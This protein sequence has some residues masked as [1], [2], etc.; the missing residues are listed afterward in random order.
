[1]TT[2]STAGF[3]PF[4]RR[5]LLWFLCASFAAV[6]IWSAWEPEIPDDWVLENLLVFIIVGV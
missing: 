6:W 5:R 3:E 1:M 2:A 4:R